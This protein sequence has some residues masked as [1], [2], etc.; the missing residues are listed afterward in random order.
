MISEAYL[1]R[2]AS[3]YHIDREVAL[4]DVAQEYVLE[5][6]RREGAF[7]DLIVFKGGTALRKFVFGAEGR[8]SVD[9]DFGVREDDD[10]GAAFVLDLL[11][12]ASFA[13]VRIA[14]ERRRGTAANLRLE[15]PLGP[16]TEP[17]AVSIRQI[18]PWLPPQVRSPLPFRF[19]DQGLAAEFARAALPV[20][21]VREAAAEKIAAFWRRR[22][23]RDLY[24]LDHLGRVLQATF[25][26]RSICALAALKIY[27]DVVEERAGGRP[28]EDLSTIFGVAPAD[29]AGK[30]DLGRFGGRTGGCSRTGGP[31][32]DAICEHDNHRRGS[33]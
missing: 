9:L 14:M 21:D 24:D 32:Q 17:A 26:G 33:S 6:Q 10:Q 2:H 3:T 16:V 29:V 8:F 18:A 13:G 11:D 7:D 1:R 23:A 28:V 20:L 31:L 25:D 12:G 22:V 15:T 27:F 30:D 5:Y 4:L 19:L